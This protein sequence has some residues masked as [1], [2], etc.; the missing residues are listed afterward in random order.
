MLGVLVKSL[1]L[2]IPLIFSG[3]LHMVVVRANLLSSLKQPI[4][5]SWFG[6]NKTWRGVVVMPLL[7]AAGAY[8][9][10]LIERD[11]SPIY[12]VGFM[13]QSTMW[14]GLLLGLT[15]IVSE[16]PN[17]YIKRRMGI[18]PGKLP[19]KNGFWFALADQ[20]DSAIGCGL[21]YWIFFGIEWAVVAVF[22]ILGTA[23]HLFFNVTLY[24]AGL[25]KNP[26]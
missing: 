24:W 1:L 14:V 2:F 25:R 26:L 19:A 12:A 20:G 4:H 17:S 18:A 11:L 13:Q 22:L 6:E 10:W 21:V 23:L 8:L 15:Y 16:L 3:V 5:R 9:S 7:T